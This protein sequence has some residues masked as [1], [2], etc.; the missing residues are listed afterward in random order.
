[1]V[2]LAR[3]MQAENSKARVAVKIVKD[4]DEDDEIENEIF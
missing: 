4:F 3:D 1:M 2:F